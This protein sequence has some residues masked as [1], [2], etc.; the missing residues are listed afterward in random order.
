MD[1]SIESYL[2]QYDEA[3][4]R[5]GETYKGMTRDER[6]VRLVGGQHLKEHAP[7]DRTAPTCPG[8]GGEPWPCGIVKGAIAYVDPHM[9]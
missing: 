4:R 8:C 5:A 3:V 9:N 2:T 7:S 6:T 1:E